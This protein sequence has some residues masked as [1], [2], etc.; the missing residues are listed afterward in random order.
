MENQRQIGKV[1]GDAKGT[2][3]ELIEY[4]EI[5]KS[6]GATHY[7]MVWSGDPEW[8]YKWFETYAEF[9]EKEIKQLKIDALKLQIE[10]LEKED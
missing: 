3:E 10:E 8:A 7:Q 4:L 1:K 9:S 6:K 2:I 5:A